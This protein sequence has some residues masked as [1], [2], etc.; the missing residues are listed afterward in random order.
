MEAEEREIDFVIY[1][2]SNLPYSKIPL[3][4]YMLEILDSQTPSEE[5]VNEDID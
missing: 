1:D 5:S 3:C 4:K 2:N